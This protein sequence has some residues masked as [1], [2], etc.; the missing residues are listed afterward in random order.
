MRVL[1]VEDENL[2]AKRIRKMVEEHEP[3]FIIE[4]ITDSIESTVNWLNTHPHP[5]LILMDIELAD[6]QSFEIFN[7]VEVK[8][9]IIFTT[10]YDEFAIRAFKVNSIDYLLKPIDPEELK[11]SFDKLKRI[12]GTSPSEVSRIDVDSIVHALREKN[13]PA[14]K[15]RFLV[16]QGQR[17]IPIDINEI[18]FFYTEDKI[19]FIKT[20]ND[21]R[22]IVD[23]SLDELEELLNPMEFFRANRQFI[24]SPRSL[25]GIH[26]HFNGKL[27]INLKPLASEEVYVSRERASDFK[28][29][30]GEE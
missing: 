27:K 3:D 8:S 5:D 10:A 1:I 25:E 21:Q 4:E 29:W 22:Y 11:K 17:L 30:L 7:R 18:A 26:H 20:F 13:V 23:H 9:T 2:A 16:K 24:V 14:F 6:G 12:T 19:S 28:K 15:Q